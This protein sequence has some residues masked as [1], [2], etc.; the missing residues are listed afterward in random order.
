MTS[1]PRV[2]PIRQGVHLPQLSIAQNSIANRAIFAMSTVS[3]KTTR[4]AVANEPVERRKS[5]VIIGRVE[6]RAR[7]IGA[8]RPAALHRPHRPAGQGAA[9]DRIH[10]FA[11]RQPEPGLVKPAV[12]D[13]S[14]D[15]DGHRSA[16]TPK[17]ET[18]I[19]IGAA[20]KDR[21]H[22]DKGQ[23]II[24][25]GWLREEPLMRRQGRFRAHDAAFAF[26]AFEEGRFLAANIGTSAHPPTKGYV[27]C[28]SEY[29][30]AGKTFSEALRIARE[31]GYP[32]PDIQGSGRAFELEL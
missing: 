30:H 29:P 7:Q 20:I 24:D 17:P 2:A 15:L 28:R 16:R 8:K 1:T 6:Q 5:L 32:G 22:R 27:Y 3:S 21:R 14:G 23:H 19:K 25:D 12:A 26:Q 18:G 13:V 4:P 11:E 10:D 31:A 9:T